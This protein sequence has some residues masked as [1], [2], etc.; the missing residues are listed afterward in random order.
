ARSTY[1]HRQTQSPAQLRDDGKAQQIAHL[2]QSSFF[3]IG[4]RR[5]GALLQRRSGLVLGESQIGRLMRQYRLNAR[6]RQI[7]KARY[8]NR[9]VKTHGL[10]GNVLNRQFY[11]RGPGEKLVTDVTYI[12]YYEAGQWHWGYL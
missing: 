9:N 4:R 12:P 5:M 2:Q 10:A 6:T 7:R 1:Y 8:V 11:A 3:T